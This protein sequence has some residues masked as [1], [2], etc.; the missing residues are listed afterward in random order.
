M[1]KI[2]LKQA[3]EDLQGKQARYEELMG[4]EQPT[5]EQMLELETLLVSIGEAEKLVKELQ[6]AEQE[7]EQPQKDTKGGKIYTIAEGVN[8]SK[9]DATKFDSV[10]ARAARKFPGEA[11]EI[12]AFSANTKDDEA[13]VVLHAEKSGMRKVLIVGLK[14]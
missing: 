11:T 6:A 14:K 3:L 7:S 10:F 4:I 12:R 9:A 5:P 13:T 1:V 2:T 8:L